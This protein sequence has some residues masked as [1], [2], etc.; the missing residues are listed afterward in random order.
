MNK[1]QDIIAKTKQALLLL[2]RLL[3]DAKAMGVDISFGVVNSD[4]YTDFRAIKVLDSTP[5]SV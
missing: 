3:R 4:G 1:E 5:K 2:S